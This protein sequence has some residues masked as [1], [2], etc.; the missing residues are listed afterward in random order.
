MG[1]LQQ[2]LQQIYLFCIYLLPLALHD[3]Q[4]KRCQVSPDWTLVRCPKMDT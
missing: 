1:A 2:M 4:V 3:A